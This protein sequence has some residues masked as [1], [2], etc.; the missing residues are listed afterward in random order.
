[1]GVNPG[2][3]ITK[4]LTLEAPVANGEITADKDTDLL[5]VF[6]FERHHATG[7]H[8]AGFVH[9]FGIHGALAQTVAHDA[10]NLLVMGDNDADMAL[11][12]NTLAE[13]GGGEVAVADGKVLGLVRLP[14]AG[15]MSD[16][17]VERVS[18]DVSVIEQ[19]WSD[20][21]CTMPSP[22]MTMGGMSLACIPELRL[23]DRGYVNCLT[24]Q[25]EPLVVE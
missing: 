16:E 15:L 25:F 8:A 3:T 22:F 4:D 11:A 7:K 21:G 10:H 5:K 17:R 20:M 14:V 19:A 23:T 6:V 2:Q 24:F 1:M 12:A 9:G 13:C 18:D